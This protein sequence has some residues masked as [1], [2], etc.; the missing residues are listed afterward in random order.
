M[1]SIGLLR[2]YIRY[3]LFCVFILWAPSGNVVA[4]DSDFPAPMQPP[5]LVNDFAGV[6]SNGQRASLEAKLLE[7]ERTSSTQITIVTMRSIGA[8]APSQY[9]V[10]LFNRWQPGSKGKDNGVLVLASMEDRKI[11]ITT[12]YGLEG[13]LTDA[14]CGR[15]IRN[16]MTPAFREGKYY[17]GFDKAAEAIIAATRGEYTADARPGGSGI[18]LRSVALIVIII[19]I[20]LWLLTR[21][22]GGG[23]Y[24]SGRG[25][26]GLGGWPLGGFGGGFGGGWSS[27]RG[28]FGGGGFGGFGGGRSGGG[29]ASGSW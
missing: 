11:N 12:G 2:Q 10:A 18:G 17:E 8:Y 26:R 6:F 20:L 3:L 16:E 23:G 7:Y 25:S 13:V 24:M 14:L 1:T 15:I 22:G 4:Q 27:G 29:G 28:G 19:I 21:G 5:Q 9:G